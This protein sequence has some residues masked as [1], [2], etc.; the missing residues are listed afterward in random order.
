MGMRICTKL[1]SAGESFTITD[2]YNA[3]S[4]SFQL[5]T[6]NGDSGTY[7]GNISDPVTSEASTSIPITPG[8]GQVF[9]SENP[10]K[11][12]AGITVTCVAGTIG[13]NIG[14]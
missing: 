5:S 9:V 6:G 13:I 11:P 7:I 14:Y 8:G 2:A 1:L 12:V 3:A 10:G 4:F